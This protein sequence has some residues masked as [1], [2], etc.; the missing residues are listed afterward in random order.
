M[1][2]Q[3]PTQLATNTAAIDQLTR[4]IGLAAKIAALPPEV[5]AALSEI[6]GD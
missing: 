2:T 6:L 4:V 1:T 5:V 3:N